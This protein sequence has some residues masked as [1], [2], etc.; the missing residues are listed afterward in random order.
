MSL[1]CRVLQATVGMFLAGV[2][3]DKQ[4]WEDLVKA[5]TDG[6]VPVKAALEENL[7]VANIN[8]AP[9]VLAALQALGLPVTQTNGKAL[10]AYQ[11]NPLVAR[12]LKYRSEKTFPA[13][14]GKHV[15]EALARSPDGRVRCN[16]LNQL[17][18]QTGRYTTSEPNMLGLPRDI[19]VRRCVVPAPGFRFV[20]ADYSSSHLRIVA[21][22]AQDPV[23]LQALNDG[24]DLHRMMGSLIAGVPE[25]QV[26]RE[27]RQAAKA[28]NF[29]LQNGA[30]VARFRIQAQADYGVILSEDE[31]TRIRDLYRKTYPGIRKWQQAVADVVDQLRQGSP[32]GGEGPDMT[33]RVSSGRTCVFPAKYTDALANE[34]QMIEAD[35]VKRA[36]VQLDQ[37]LPDCG[38]RLLL[39]IHDEL[40]IEVPADKAD[41]VRELVERTMREA[42]EEV[43]PGVPIVVEADVRTTW[44]KGVGQ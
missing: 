6:L 30:G 23:M 43:V 24:R 11:S 8:S 37:V 5:T 32:F 38:A 21:S 25:D 19:A 16:R 3:V 31:A 10:G 17:G 34:I 20:C 22:V 4:A 41:A 26:T 39:C 40:L 2:G 35:G 29:G 7:G 9:K 42:M 1:E 27:Q 33:I 12:L 44:A 15:M 14:H 18:T 28:A 13:N 36:L